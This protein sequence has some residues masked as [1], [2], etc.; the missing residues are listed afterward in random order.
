MHKVPIPSF[1]ANGSSEWGPDD[2]L[3]EA[4]HLAAQRK[5]GL[6]RCARNEDRPNERLIT[7]AQSNAAMQR[8]ADRLRAGGTVEEEIGDPALGEPEAEPAAIFEPALVADGRHHGA[9]AGDGGD[10]AGARAKGLHPAAVD[11]GFDATAEQMRP[12]S[13]DLDE[14]GT[15]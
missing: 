2:R 9:V 13:A 6:L 8:V 7:D 12:L 14:T 1:R 3:R 15:V 11:V 4:I 5:N 10:D